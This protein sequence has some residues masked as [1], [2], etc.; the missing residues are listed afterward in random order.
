[1]SRAEDPPP[2]KQKS[3]RKSLSHV[4]GVGRF[5]GDEA[6]R[7][8][9]ERAVDA[10]ADGSERAVTHGFHPWPGRLHP[11]TA[12]ELI[13]VAPPGVIADPFMGAGTVPLEALRE[14]RAAYGNDL[15][16]IGSEVAWVRS[17]RFSPGALQALVGRA[18]LVV[19]K[20]EAMTG[21]VDPAFRDALTRWFDYQALYEV[22]AIAKCL[23]EGDASWQGS[24][25][26]ALTRVLRMALS[27]IVVKASRQ[28]SDSVAKLDK[29]IT[30]TTPPGRVGHWFRKRTE[31]LA[32]QLQALSAEVPREVPEPTFVLGDAR[33]PPADRPAFGAIISSPP[34][35]G[36]YDYLTHHALRCTV[37][38]LP[39]G[40]ATQH[41]IGS[42]RMSER[43]GKTAAHAR[44][45]D[46]LGKVLAAW[47]E[48]LVPGGF[49]ALMIG[50]GQVGNEVVRVMP[51][52]DKAATAA[53]LVVRASVSQGRPTFGPP[54]ANEQS[55]RK[56]EHL[57]WLE[58]A[59]ELASPHAGQAETP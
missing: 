16:P 56:D 35:P 9:L 32:G 11:H 58:R 48:T 1:M 4:G 33:T 25:G 52:L 46:D 5:R 13:R 2:T 22:W 59:P 45:V 53:K 3:A 26:D 51:L 8:L 6:L 55:P 37:L 40:D 54:T 47:S 14:G 19:K 29:N 23:R 36:V 27:S 10:T 30:E 7:P 42:R 18:K 15:N 31:E 17:R 43:L 39:M 50:D 28:V 44:Y 41:E 49:V 34:Y 24:P 57:V 12:R 38:G 20:A 21:D